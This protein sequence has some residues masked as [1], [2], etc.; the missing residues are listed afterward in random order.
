MMLGAALAAVGW[1]LMG[2]VAGDYQRLFAVAILVNLATVFASTVMGGLM[3]EAGQR[4]AIPG[5]ISS[6]RQVVE[7][8]SLIAAPLL[9]GYLAGRAFGW[10]AAIAAACTAGLAS[11]TFVA[12]RERPRPAVSPGATR[13]DYRPSSVTLVG[14]VGI[15]AVAGYLCS[16][17][18]LR[19][20][21][22]SLWA[23]L[24]S[25]LLILAIVFA[26]FANPVLIRAQGQLVLALESRTL[27][28]AAGMLFLVY[29]VPGL[30]TALT[31]RQT[32]VL[33]FDKP[34]IG[35]MAALEAGTGVVAALGY[36]LVCRRLSLR[37]LLAGGIGLNAAATLLYLLYTRESAPLVHATTGFAVILSELALMH[38]AVRSTPRGCEAL[39][40]SLMMSVRNFGV[41]MSDVLATKL[42]DRFHV[43]FDALVV[44]NAT[45]TGLI[46]LLLP[47]LPAAIVSRRDGDA[48][49]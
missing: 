30:F 48:V 17:P 37:V 31:Y 49:D 6:L 39:G 32:D 41:G 21:G 46:V 18:E 26:R 29:T 1:A 24:A 43:G 36:G 16:L 7:G 15:G 23:L 3:V 34:F 2:A 44:T 22:V 33:K 9:G 47:L 42:V 5:R 8:S 25:F 4:F 27:W 10:T 40:F 20:I 35:A 12:L 13:P 28:L 38:L 45:T 19:N 11:L 14:I